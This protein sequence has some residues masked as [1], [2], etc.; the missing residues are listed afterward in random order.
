[1]SPY[2]LRDGT[3]VAVRPIRSDDAD[4]LRESHARLSPESKYR[5]F[6]SAKPELTVADARYL[7]DIDGCDH[8]ALVATLDDEAESIIAVARFV[9]LPEHPETAEFAIVVADAYQ[10][11][12]LATELMKRLGGAAAQR[13]VKRFRAT[14]LSDN[15]ATRKLLEQV[16]CGPLRERRHGGTCEVDIDLSACAPTSG[17]WLLR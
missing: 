15:L 6:L 17:A 4:R 16:A 5:R 1:M 9:R 11:Q 8:F 10:H 7:V 3:A 14:M 12:G 2:L 13:G